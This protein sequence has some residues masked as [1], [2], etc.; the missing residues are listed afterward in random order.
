MVTLFEM[1]SMNGVPEVSW[2]AA[3]PVLSLHHW[4]QLP[5]QG[6]CLP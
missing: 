5:G 4:C 3:A 6:S 2:Q 1:P